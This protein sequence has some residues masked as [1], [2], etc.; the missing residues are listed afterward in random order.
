M[1]TP[2]NETDALPQHGDHQ[3]VLAV[4]QARGVMTCST[5]AFDIAQ[6][7]PEWLGEHNTD[8]EDQ[9]PEPPGPDVDTDT[10]LPVQV[11]HEVKQRPQPE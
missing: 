9:N 5:C 4:D 1:E 7:P 3:I 10:G 11:E 2:T 6:M 8:V